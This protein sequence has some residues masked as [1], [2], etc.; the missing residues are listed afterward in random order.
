MR[1]CDYKRKFTEGMDWCDLSDNPCWNSPEY[2]CDEAY[3]DEEDEP[4]CPVCE[5]TGKEEQDD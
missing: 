2:P 1:I 4:T 3:D 5:G